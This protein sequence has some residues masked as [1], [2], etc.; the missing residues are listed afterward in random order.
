MLWGETKVSVKTRALGSFVMGMALVAAVSVGC[1][2]DDGDLSLG[3]VMSLELGS[4][5]DPFSSSFD[6]DRYESGACNL[7]TCDPDSTYYD[8]F[9][10]DECPDEFVEQLNE[11]STTTTEPE[12]TDDSDATDSSSPDSTDV[13]DDADTQSQED[14][15]IPATTSKPVTRTVPASTSTTSTTVPPTTSSAPPTT[16][17]PS[18]ATTTLPRSTGGTSTLP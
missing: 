18:G 4:R 7:A 17:K 10:I 3:G 16:K 6:E 12:G 11:R 9:F 13:E 8:P 5:C 1:G 2:G 15:T 14:S